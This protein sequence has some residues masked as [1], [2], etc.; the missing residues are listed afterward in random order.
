MIAKEEINFFIF[1]LL[2]CH[3]IRDGS[4]KGSGQWGMGNGTGKQFPCSH[5]PFPTD[6]SLLILRPFCFSTSR[7]SKRASGLTLSPLS[8][9]GRSDPPPPDACKL[10]EEIGGAR[11]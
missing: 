4:G 8:L 3:R 5:S 2:T 6:H 10:V 1:L 7:Y 9:H 11:I